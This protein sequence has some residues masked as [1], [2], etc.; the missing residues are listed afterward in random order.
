[1]RKRTFSISGWHWVTIFKHVQHEIS[2][3]AVSGI[4]FRAKSSPQA[5]LMPLC[6][7]KRGQ[8]TTRSPS[9]SFPCLPPRA[10]VAWVSASPWTTGPR[11]APKTPS[12][13]YSSS[14][15][16]GSPLE[17]TQPLLLSIQTSLASLSPLKSTVARAP[18]TSA[19]WIYCLSGLVPFLGSVDL[20]SAQRRQGQS[21]IP[22]AEPAPPRVLLWP[23]ARDLISPGLG[24]LIYKMGRMRVSIS[25]F[26]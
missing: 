25:M 8:I 13:A 11:S 19:T 2:S 12:L 14:S 1:M 4:C 17:T 6:A 16:L 5:P 24:F 10:P 20:I 3:L 26:W 21:F 23:Q 15:R 9:K 22:R 7:G 18:P